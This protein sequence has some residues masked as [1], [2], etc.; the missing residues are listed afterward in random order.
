MAEEIVYWFLEHPDCINCHRASAFFVDDADVFSVVR[1]G[2]LHYQF[3]SYLNMPTCGAGALYP[4]Y[5]FCLDVLDKSKFMEYSP[6][7]D[8]LWFWAMAALKGYKVNVV[9]DNITKLDYVGETQNGPCLKYIN[10]YGKRLFWVSLNNIVTEY[11]EFKRKLL[12]ACYG[13]SVP[14]DKVLPLK[15]TVNT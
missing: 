3:P 10:N 1:G 13:R 6:T 14:E 4:P 7:N 15:Y 8:D 11:P 12:V 9:K 2:N 5:C